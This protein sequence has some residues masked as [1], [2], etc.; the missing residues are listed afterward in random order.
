MDKQLQNQVKL[1][2]IDALKGIAMILVIMI[3]TGAGQKL[4]GVLSL[5]GKN[6]WCGVVL[7]LLISAFL[8]YKS[9]HSY[10]SNATYS[11]KSIKEWIENRFLRFIPLFYLAVLCGLYLGGNQHWL[12]SEKGITIG[13]LVAHLFFVH[14]FFP[15]YCDSILGVEWYIGVLA[16]FICMVPFIFKYVNNFTKSI[17]VFLLSIPMVYYINVYLQSLTPFSNAADESVYSSFVNSFGFFENLPPLL[18]GIVLYYVY[19][20]LN[21]TEI[22]SKLMSYTLL[23]A[24]IVLIYGTLSGR[25]IIF[26]TNKHTLWGIVFSLLIISQMLYQDKL[27]CNRFFQIIGKYSWPIYLFH[28]YL[29]GIY[30]KFLNMEIENSIASWG[31]E[32]TFVLVSSLLLSWLLMKFFNKPILDWIFPQNNASNTGEIKHD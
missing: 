11:L 12:G 23:L 18:L 7:F 5:L 31:V 22:K 13:N 20:F 15:R 25:N 30:R 19:R 1:K 16:I 32:F 10:F 17:L 2:W 4:P 29:V 27:V 14:G 8:L 3:H 24:S 28:F 9:L 6:G 21:E 26:L